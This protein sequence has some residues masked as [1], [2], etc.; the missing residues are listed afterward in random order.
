[1]DYIETA[2][3][4]KVEYQP[5]EHTK[6]LP[7]YI[8]ERYEVRQAMI[9][10]VKTICVYPRLELEQMASVRKQIQR[11]QRLE[12]LPVVIIMNNI[13]RNRRE[14]MISSKIP[15]VVP[16]KQLYLPFMGAVLQERF[17]AEI[18]PVQRLQPSA[19]VLFFYYLYQKEK[20]IYMSEATKALGFSGMTISR[21]VRQLEQTELFNTKKEGVLKIL[22][23]KYGGRELFE[24][25]KPYLISPVRKVVYVNKQT[26]IP[27]SFIA[28]L[29]AL[30]EISMINPPNIAC[31]AVNGKIEGLKGTDV[32]LDADIQKEV[33]IWKYDPS[34][35][36][37]GGMADPLSLI[38]T[39]KDDN[40]ER[41]E[42]A[43]EEILNG[44]WE[45]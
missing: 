45:E 36:G 38:M 31:Y 22:T 19:Q 3:G 16:D 17:S 6:E 9:G 13:N 40:D 43:I 5:W 7:Y 25:M 14:Y 26:E 18:C 15:F 34:I 30:S 10:D 1:M 35:L 21:A 24:K 11:I 29:S 12:A 28:G 2:L 37:K 44:I 41:V 8:L 39:F 20:Q 42:E 32:L 23:G 27:G 4:V 33:Q